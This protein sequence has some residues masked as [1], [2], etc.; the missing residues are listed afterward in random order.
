MVFKH[1]AK[2]CMSYSQHMLFSLGLSKDFFIAS[3]K[4]FVHAIYPD[5]Y[6][7][8]SSD[9]IIDIDNKMK[10]VGCKDEN[11]ERNKTIEDKSI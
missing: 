10:K 1:P 11:N 6:I 9:A 7:T 3:T 8:S 5:S 4:A 2:V